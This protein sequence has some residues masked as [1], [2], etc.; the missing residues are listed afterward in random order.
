MMMGAFAAALGACNDENT[1]TEGFRFDSPEVSDVSATAA[2]VTCRVVRGAAALDDLPVEFVCAATDDESAEEV[3]APATAGEGTVAARLAGLEPDTRYAVYARMRSGEFEV[4]SET[5]TFT[6]E[7]VAPGETLLEILTPTTLA[8]EAK[9]GRFAIDYEVL[10]PQSEA[11]AEASC[12]AA[13]VRGFD[14]SAAGTIAF[15]VDANTGAAR[16][17]EIEVTCTGA[18]SRRIAV[19]QAAGT[20]TP[21]QNPATEVDLTAETAGWPESYGTAKT[22]QLDGHAFEVADV[23]TGYGNGIQFKKSSGYIANREDMG[24]IRRIEVT[25][26]GSERC[27][28]RL[29]LGDEPHPVGDELKPFLSDG[30]YLFDCA[31]RAAHWFTLV[32]GDG[33]SYVQRIRIV[34]GGEGE[35]PTPL[36]KPSFEAPGYSAVTKNSATISCAYA[37]SGEGTVSEVYFLY[38]P[39]GSAAA[40]RVDLT[41]A[42]GAKS[43]Q[44]TGL[45]AA[46]RYVFRLR[47]VIDGALFESTEG[48][49]TTL[50]ESGGTVGGDTKY[51]G[52]PELPVEVAD[53]DYYY[54]YHIC[55]D[56]NAGGHA[57]RNFTVCYSAEHHC[58]VWVAAPVHECYTG[59]SGNR[60]YGPDPVIPKSIQ[61]S[62]KTVAS[63]YN[64]GHMLGNRERSRTS[65]MNKQVSYYTNMAAQH[66]S[67]FNTGGGAWNNL[68]DKIDD[69]WCADTLYTVSGCRF[70][71]WTDSYGNAASPKRVSFGGVQASVPTMF[72]TLLLRTKRGNTG[73]SVADC[74]R[75]ELQ[76]VAFVMSH[77]MGK[78]HQP[79]AKDMRSVAEIERLTGFRFFENV[80][81][82]PKDTYNPSDWGL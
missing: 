16:T 77:A 69:Y 36:V 67:T 13:W 8:V 68:E 44:L 59:G 72:Y 50:T 25:Y 6:T 28:L 34:C 37:Y 60:N 17:A 7:A 31:D 76:C 18:E 71:T 47:V 55:P 29:C 21:P 11:P 64:K 75:D 80:P 65:G 40:T 81:N 79:S 19:R 9:G 56:F 58:P 78:G 46:T 12:D 53:E 35:D 24:P 2:T 54:A 45:A 23:G 39:N 26:K 38:G 10:N 20:S 33:A 14:N 62:S 3:S 1:A 74:S 73:K 82:A 15:E 63:P 66:G 61:P 70:E 43:A 42:Q 22:V 30:I 52:W 32:S 48:T 5:A 4:R 41:T 57:A 49:F 27:N 51:G